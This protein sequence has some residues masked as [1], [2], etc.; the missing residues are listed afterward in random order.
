MVELVMGEFGGKS[1]L[2][3]A[4]DHKSLKIPSPN[5]LPG[6]NIFVPYVMVADDAFPLNEHIMKP[7]GVKSLVRK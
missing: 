2:K 3:K 4:I 6:T 7:F 5:K 1:Q